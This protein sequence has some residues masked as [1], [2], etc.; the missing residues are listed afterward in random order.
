MNSFINA[1]ILVIG[2]SLSG[3]TSLINRYTTDTFEE[4]PTLVYK[5]HYKIIK[6]V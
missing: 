2:D 1:K 4:S 5:Y 3:K 6:N